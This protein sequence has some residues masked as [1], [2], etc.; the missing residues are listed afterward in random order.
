MKRWAGLVLAI[1]PVVAACP[2]AAAEPPPGVH[3]QEVV[4]GFD[5]LYRCG[6]MVPIFVLINNPLQAPFGGELQATQRDDD[7]DSIRWRAEAAI[8][9]RGQEWRMVLVCPRHDGLETV[10]VNLV[11]VAGGA[12]KPVDTCDLVGL[13]EHSR[14]ML[15]SLPN[16]IDRERRVV[17]IIGNSIGHSLAGLSTIV[18]GQT[19]A[20]TGE[21]AKLISMP[22]E[23]FP[24]LWQALDSVDVIYWDDADPSVLDIEQQRA[25]SQW[26][27]RGG[28]LV[29]GLGIKS[30]GLVG[31][32]SELA[33]LLPVDVL[34]TSQRVANLHPLGR[35]L[36]GRYYGNNFSEPA[37]VV[38]VHPR[39]GVRPWLSPADQGRSDLG[40]PLLFRA[41]R[42]AGSI[43]VMCTSLEGG[44][45][46]RATPD[47]LAAQA[48]LLGFNITRSGNNSQGGYGYNE[49]S[50]TSGISDYLASGGS[51]WLIVLAV[52]MLLAY[53]L[54][55]GPGTWLY[56]QHRNQRHLSWWFFGAVV[57]AATL[58]SLLLSVVSI[59]GVAVS[60]AVVLDLP[61]NSSYAVCR[62]YL[63]LYEPAH[64]TSLVELM[65]DPAGRLIPMIEP[66][67]RD[68]ATY[69]DVREYDIRQDSLTQLAPPVRR[70]VKQLAIDWRGEAGG[71]VHVDGPLKVYFDPNSAKWQIAG[72]LR[73]SLPVDL[74]HARLVFLPPFIA[75]GLTTE[76]ARPLTDTDALWCR[77]VDLGDI[78]KGSSLVFDSAAGPS[79]RALKQQSL[80]DGQRSAV[81]T[82]LAAL[83]G[84]H[85]FLERTLMLSTLSLFDQP[86]AAQANNYMN[87]S[88]SVRRGALFKFDRGDEIAAGKVLLIAEARDFLPA[89]IRVSHVTVPHSG[90]T[91]VRVILDCQVGD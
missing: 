81:G 18:A 3:M 7:G 88:R 72:S 65:G 86:E 62:G 67:V 87:E 59:R 10:R 58:A 39:A 5:G 23:R 78:A 82:G 35:A 89:E 16:P 56:A 30:Q 83:A 47:E 11:D 91:V 17:G 46:D 71:A 38:A 76:K 84:G 1:L 34:T 41:D 20:I 28:Q 2:A 73:N 22:L 74:S 44:G 24:A 36:L 33:R 27:W 40:P 29:V 70:T 26:V 69:P 13:D 25:L 4:V 8:R 77:V 6:H 31:S 75:P 60:S 79:G 66:D 48:R 50:L 9:P 54:L 80:H 32:D 14:A 51:N 61:V 68:L 64:S 43:T 49:I 85:P 52:L 45:F 53:G 21:P 63:G 57:G 55:A 42:G 12:A 37:T 90:S 15:R 19:G